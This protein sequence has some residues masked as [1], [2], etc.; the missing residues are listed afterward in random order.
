MQTEYLNDLNQKYFLL[1]YKNDKTEFSLKMICENRI[2]GLV[3]CD[4]RSINEEYWIYYDISEVQSMKNLFV[5]KKMS[6][7]EFNRL[8][9]DWKDLKARLPEYFLSD[10]MLLLRPDTIFYDIRNCHFRFLLLPESFEEESSGSIKQ[11]AEFLIRMIDHD[12]AELVEKVYR[13][14]D[15]ICS[16]EFCLDKY[17]AKGENHEPAYKKEA[18]KEENHEKRGAVEAVTSLQCDRQTEREKKNVFPAKEETHLPEE[19]HTQE[20]EEKAKKPI[21]KISIF[22]LG[23][24]FLG[25]MIYVILLKDILA[26]E[27]AAA[28]AIMMVIVILLVRIIFSSNRKADPDEKK[29]EHRKRKEINNKDYEKE[30]EK[31]QDVDGEETEQKEIYE[32]DSMRTVYMEVTERQEKKLYGLGKNKSSRIELEHFPFTIGKNK[33]FSDFQLTDHSVSRVHAR[34]F[35]EGETVVLTDLNSTNGTYHNGFRLQQEQKVIME[36]EDEVCFG[37]VM[38]VYR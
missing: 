31:Y 32:E 6:E 27:S 29:M 14:Y 18:E 7:V 12:S 19:N 20:Q 13:F 21:L 38:Y 35:L 28:L 33:E 16:G 3:P 37:K 10:R 11:L 34:F 22:V 23:I 25:G 4:L 36:P 5:K 1:N 8:L 9:S 24:L 30:K 2:K 17:V 26:P 15:E